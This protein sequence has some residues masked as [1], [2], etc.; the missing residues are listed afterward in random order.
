MRYGFDE[1]DEKELQVEVPTAAGTEFKLAPDEMNYRYHKPTAKKPTRVPRIK[2][3]HPPPPPDLSQAG[4]TSGTQGVS[5][6]PSDSMIDLSVEDDD[7]PLEDHGAREEVEGDEQPSPAEPEETP[8][9]FRERKS[10]NYYPG[11]QK[12]A[13]IEPDDR[14]LSSIMIYRSRAVP[15]EGVPLAVLVI[16]SR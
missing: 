3:P 12:F 10:V 13:I 1:E 11:P 7:L 5:H 16:S 2:V 4:P 9:E 6:P 8:Y 15:Q 14:T